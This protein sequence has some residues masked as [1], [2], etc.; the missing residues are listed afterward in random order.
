MMNSVYWLA[1]IGVF[2]GFGGGFLGFY[3]SML[4]A[5]SDSERRFIKSGAAGLTLYICSFLA[6]LFLL[7]RWLSIHL[8]GCYAFFLCLIIR[9][10]NKQHTG[11]I[12][13]GE[14]Q[15]ESRE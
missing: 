10:M 6:L 2:I 9:K 4:R 5:K 3:M 8:F 14:H 7:P 11:L 1:A 13:A 12:K 15:S